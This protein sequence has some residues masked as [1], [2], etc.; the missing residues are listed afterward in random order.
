[1]CVCVCACVILHVCVY[2]LVC[3]LKDD[4]II[5]ALGLGLAQLAVF[6]LVA[7]HCISG[8]V[9]P[10]GAN[11]DDE[12]TDHRNIRKDARKSKSLLRKGFRRLSRLL[13]R[14]L[15]KPVQFSLCPVFL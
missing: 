10:S 2:V 1:M 9:T 7:C 8:K 15:L 12:S 14:S 6:A 13:L 4:T 3:V 5:K 11:L